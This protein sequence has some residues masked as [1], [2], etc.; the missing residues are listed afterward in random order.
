MAESAFRG[1]IVFLDKL[2]VY[3]VILPFLLTFTIFFAI[4]ERTKVLGMEKI[5]GEPYT[6][7]NLNAMVAFVVAFLVVASVR[8]VAIIHTALPNIVLLLLVS[9]SFLM[10]VG[11]FYKE[12]EPVALEGAWRTFIMVIIFIGVAMIFAAAIP[13]KDTNWLDYWWSYTITNFDSTAVSSIV[14]I[15][16]LIGMMVWVTKHPTKGEKE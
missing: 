14:L 7:K 11:T 8:M 15:I 4:L 1:V 16:F 10:L 9:I 5:E 2:G 6:K 3:D 12:D 13:Y